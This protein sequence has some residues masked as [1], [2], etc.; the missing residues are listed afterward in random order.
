M[1]NIEKQIFDYIHNAYR[2]EGATQ[3]DIAKL[4]G[5][6]QS[7]VCRIMSGKSNVGSLSIKVIEKL[8]PHATLNIDGSPSVKGF[9]N[10]VGNNNSDIAINAS[11]L[12]HLNAIRD[13]IVENEK[14][15]ADAKVEVLKIIKASL[16]K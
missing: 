6:S 8:F 9:G 15:S 2:N 3:E 10:V 13:L 16:T 4:L 11:N 1:N 7:H 14:L 5:V 12:E